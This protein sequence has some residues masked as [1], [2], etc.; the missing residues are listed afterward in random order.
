MDDSYCEPKID[1]PR[2]AEQCAA[3]GGV[4][5][6][7]SEGDVTQKPE[8]GRRDTWVRPTLGQPGNQPLACIMYRCKATLVCNCSHSES[9]KG[10]QRHLG[11]SR[12]QSRTKLD[13]ESI[14]K[15]QNPEEQ[16]D[17]WKLKMMLKD[18]QT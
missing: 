5:R 9:R 7:R 14:V 3:P 11:Q 18:S 6:G 16:G 1:L 8:E 13:S 17:T 12:N 15:A 2:W 4:V 10:K